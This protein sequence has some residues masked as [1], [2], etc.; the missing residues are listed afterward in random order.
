MVK[1]TKKYNRKMRNTSMKSYQH[2]SECP[3]ASFHGI[4]CWYKYMFE[5]LGW[6][7][8]AKNYGMMD[9]VNSYKMS[10]KRI[11]CTI[12]TK[13]KNLRDHDKK[14]D[15]HILHRN[16]CMLMEHAEKDL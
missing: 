15:M 5:K 13:I 7:I 1:Q 4:E 16:I 2:Y 11:K 10:L 8:L 12:E 6:M 9:K 14:E 3:D